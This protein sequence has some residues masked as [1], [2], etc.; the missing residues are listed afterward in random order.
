MIEQ[1]KKMGT[2]MWVC[3]AL[4]V[5]ALVALAVGISGT[6]IILPLIACTAMMGMM[7]WMMMGIGHGGNKK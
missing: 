2:G 6:W 7:M 4:I 5:A 3:V 1:A